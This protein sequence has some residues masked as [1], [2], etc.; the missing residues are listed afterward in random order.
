MQNGRPTIHV[1]DPDPQVRDSVRDLTSSL[2]LRSSTY[3][4]GREFFASHADSEPGCVV[5][6]VRIPDMSGLQ[7]QR[8]MSANGSTLPLVFL[9]A[10]ADVSLAVELMRAGA[11]HYL[12]KPMRPLD[13]INAIQE[14]LAIDQSRREATRRQQEIAES[15]AVLSA[16]ERHVLR[17]I[18]QG[19][20]NDA[21]GSELG[22]AIRTVELR[23][24]RLMKK[25]GVRSTIGLVHFALQASENGRRHLELCA[26]EA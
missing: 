12:L 5:L 21:I 4:T 22:I 1:I 23:R 2:N 15:V 7:I 14:A 26:A 17:L 16:K 11:V 13:V 20:S 10:Q 19:L 3:A 6:E 18:A 25:L 8:R 9:S 24:A